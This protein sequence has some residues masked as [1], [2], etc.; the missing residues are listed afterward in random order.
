M[1]LAVGV[2]YVCGAVQFSIVTRAGLAET[3][4][5]AVYYFVLIDL[6]KAMAA[7]AIGAA[8]LPSVRFGPESD[9]SEPSR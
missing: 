1:M 8:V 6:A 4:V 7:A 9:G 2:I 5:K 3:L